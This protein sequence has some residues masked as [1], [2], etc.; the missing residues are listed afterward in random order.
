MTDRD[1][2]SLALSIS[3]LGVAAASFMV[4]WRNY[5]RDSGRLDVSVSIGDVWGGQPIQQE[6]HVI[7]IRVVNSGRR[8]IMLESFGGNA[9]YYLIKRIVHRLCS[10]SKMDKPSWLFMNSALIDAQFRPLGQPKVLQEGQSVT[11]VIPYDNVIAEQLA[12]S[13]SLYV[14][15]SM[16]R[17]HKVKCKARRTLR[18][19]WKDEVKKTGNE[20]T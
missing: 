3:S 16:S 10:K 1:L 4:S 11:V 7:Y 18:R 15:D 5:S 13:S 2:V 20:L 9:R 6:Q 19:N 14:F 12:T 8:P 17:K